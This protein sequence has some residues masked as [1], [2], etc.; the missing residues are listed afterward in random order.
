M[1][2]LGIIPACFSSE[3]RAIY[4]RS[5]EEILDFFKDDVSSPS[6][7]KAELELWRSHFIGKELPK[8]PSNRLTRNYF[9]MSG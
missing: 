9:Q 6:A 8:L 7:A 2:C 1:R 3:D 5:D 4:V